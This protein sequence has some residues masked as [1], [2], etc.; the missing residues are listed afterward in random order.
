[1]DCSISVTPS[2]YL[3][4]DVDPHPG[5]G[6][7]FDLPHAD[8]HL[9]QYQYSCGELTGGFAFVAY[10]AEY[11]SSG[12]KT[13]IA[14]PDGVVYEKDLGRETAKVAASMTQYDPDPGWHIAG[15]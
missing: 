15:H 1:M 8:G 2:L 13:F 4:G 9:S 11:G 6:V 12:V 10:P 14:G 5:D 3:R 7:G